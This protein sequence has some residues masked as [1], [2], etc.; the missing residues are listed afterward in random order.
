MNTKQKTHKSVKPIAILVLMTTISVMGAE[1]NYY[2]KSN[3]LLPANWNPT[4]AANDVID[5]LVTVTPEHVKGAHDADMVLIDNYAYIV[6][7]A[8]DQRRGEDPRWDYVY[9]AMAIVNIEIMVVENWIPFAAS[10]QEFGNETLPVGA[11]FVPRII[12][13]DTETL[14]VFFSSENPGVRQSQVWYRDFDIEDRKFNSNINRVQLKTSNGTFDMQPQYFY[15]DAKAQGFEREPRDYGIYPFDIKEFDGKLYAGINNFAEGHLAFAEINEELDTF[16]I[17]GHF[18]EPQDRGLNEMAI[19]RLPD[20]IWVAICRVARGVEGNYCVFTTSKDGRS[21]TQG[22]PH[23]FVPN[24]ASSKPTFDKFNEIY[25]LGW[26]EHTPERPR[27]VFN[28]DVS[29]D[30]KNW[31]R[32][33]RFTT[34]ENYQWANLFQY[35]EFKEHKGS[36]WVCVTDR[37]KASIVFGKLEDIDSELDDDVAKRGTKVLND[38]YNRYNNVLDTLDG[39]FRILINWCYSAL[40]LFDEGEQTQRADNILYETLKDQSTYF[41][42]RGSTGHDLYWETVILSR[43]INAPEMTVKLSDKTQQ[44]IKAVLWDFVYAF[45]KPGHS[46]PEIDKI[47]VIHNSDNH[48]MIHR[49]LYLM[50]A[51]ALKDDPL[52]KNKQYADGSIASQRY[53]LWV[54][55]LLEYFRFRA[56]NGVNVEVSC[57]VYAGVH[58]Q[59]IFNIYDYCQDQELSEQAGKFL[60]LF[61]ADAAQEIIN[62]IRGG[63]KVRMPKNQTSYDYR[64]DKLYG[65]T[66]ALAGV[67]EV[68]PIRPATDSFPAM[69]TKYRLPDI[70]R[71]LM[72]NE[73]AKGSYSYKSNRLGQGNHILGNEYDTGV[74]APIYTAEV[75]S[76]LLRYTYATPS[77]LLGSFTVDET[78]NY[79]LINAQ[80]QWMGLITADSPQSRIV[81]HLT[82]TSSVDSKMGYRELQAVQYENTAM[83]KKQL[84]ADNTALMR[85]FV[86]DDFGM[87]EQENVLLFEN[88]AVYAAVIVAHQHGRT[89]YEI[90]PTDLGPGK[91][92]V[93]NEPNVYLVL[94]AAQKSEYPSLKDF[95]DNLTRLIDFENNADIADYASDKVRLKM[96]TYNRLPEINGKHVD[97]RPEKIYDSPYI[98][99]YYN[100]PF[101]KITGINGESIILDFDYSERN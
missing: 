50:T 93:F 22:Q 54:K 1:I 46:H 4:E 78:K 39:N 58:L 99:G 76:G 37:N 49:G 59:P 63:A 6:T 62:G 35:P 12:Q 101:V 66:H 65:Y 85:L 77:Y 84:A 13:K 45:D 7:M 30:G 79:M 32:K 29:L 75:Q 8:N 87:S 2:A 82:A 81:V 86:S 98:K 60:T 91:F 10:E 73:Q 40:V 11:I 90:Q 80:S 44:A 3:N 83:F 25:Y 16:E 67:P 9:S 48:D 56:V 34:P 68:V 71:E 5:R 72:T 74:R 47:N 52:W 100:S 97:V 41:S 95:S 70:V 94:K 18:F 20:G 31:E 27:S 28:V 36:I 26:Q 15:E 33:Y 19:N 89:G 43:I 92:V 21:W 17:L 57:N 42:N 38:S 24:A 53:D 61:F 51:Q 14:R 88:D 96:F 23:D 55:N 69:N 64:F